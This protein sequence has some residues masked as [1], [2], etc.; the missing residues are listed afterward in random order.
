MEKHST[1]VVVVGSFMSDVVTYVNRLPNGGETIIGSQ[2]VLCCGGKG[3]NQCVTAAR[4]GAK[5]SMV[6]KLGKDSFGEEHLKT[7]TTEG[8]DTTHITFTDEALT[9][10]GQLTVLPDGKNR[11]ITVSGANAYLTVDDIISA[12][13]MI[14]TAQVML[15]EN[16]IEKETALA[17]LQMANDLGVLT[18]L[19]AAPALL[20]LD[21]KFFKLSDI[22]CVNETEAEVT[23][24]LPVRSLDEAAASARCLL[25]KGCKNHVLITLGDQGAVLLSR[26]DANKPVHIKTPNVSAIDT[27]G[28]GDC[29]LGALAFFLA[30]R[31]ELSLVKA[32]EYACVVSSV[33]VQR[34]GT[35][36]SFPKWNE[37]SELFP[38]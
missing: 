31:P 32:I 36:P 30:T 29:F 8:V 22:F 28:A 1:Q 2:L 25:E 10:V 6:G 15:C 17:A 5:T 7:M 33:S 9:G 38:L 18:I 23:S 14:S 11:V 21:A 34:N 37:L 19:N 26:Q 12:K 27:T 24:G 13:T 4:L 20:E 16:Q 35:Q 3:A